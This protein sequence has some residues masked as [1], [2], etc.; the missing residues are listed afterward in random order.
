MTEVPEWP[1]ETFSIVGQ[2]LLSILSVLWG[3]WYEAGVGDT[4]CTGQASDS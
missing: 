4:R 2:E 3:I 1:V